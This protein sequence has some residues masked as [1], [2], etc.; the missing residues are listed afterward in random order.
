MQPVPLL[1]RWLALLALA[2]ALIGFGWIKGASHVQAQW[3]TATS[4]Q[5]LRVAHVRQ[6][7]AETT[8]KVVTK[9]TER[10]RTV[11]AAGE[12]IIKEVPVYVS[13]TAPDLPGGFRL[14]HDAAARGEPPTSAGSA[15]APSVA[16]RT[17]AETVISNYTA[18]RENAE[19]LTALQ[20]WVRQQHEIAATADGQ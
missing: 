8:V 13:A 14:L 11:R 6:R 19:Q 3:D 2:G 12:T 10:V 7:Q 18:C 15:D 16:A 4:K 1:Y 5:S 9:Y 20:A 17:V